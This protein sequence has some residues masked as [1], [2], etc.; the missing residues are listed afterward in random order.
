MVNVLYGCAAFAL[1]MIGLLV[2]YVLVALLPKIKATVAG[3]NEEVIPKIGNVIEN[4][5][6]VTKSFQELSETEIKPMMNNIQNLTGQ[7]N[8]E[9]PKIGT[10]LENVNSITGNVNGITASIQ[11]LSETEIKGIAGNIQ[12]ITGRISEEE[13]P[14]LGATFENV[15]GITGNVNGIT[16]SIQQL[17]ETEI[18]GI[19]GNIQE[20][21]GKINEDLAKVDEV[22]TTTTDF[23]KNTIEKVEFY[24]DK[25]F[26]PIIDILSFWNAVKT[27]L[28][29]ISQKKNDDKRGGD[30]NG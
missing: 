14:K 10:T 7:L 12:E 8:E 17:S 3:I 4:L 18:K 13:I 22:V 16:S 28:A 23:T 5:D 6:G 30:S 1:G 2:I 20:I 24:R 11:Q 21:T 27:G 25:L 9:I 29:S 26:V 19:V 15:S